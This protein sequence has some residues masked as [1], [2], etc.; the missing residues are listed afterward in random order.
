MNQPAKR[1]RMRIRSKVAYVVLVVLLDDEK[2]KSFDDA[3]VHDASHD[4]R[5][6][7]GDWTSDSG[8]TLPL[9]SDNPRRNCEQFLL[10]Y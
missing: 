2:N 4:E 10:N 8:C 9:L 6:D 7:A 3:L 1:N 5:A